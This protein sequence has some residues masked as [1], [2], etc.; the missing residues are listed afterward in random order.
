MQEGFVSEIYFATVQ[1]FARFGGECIWM[2]NFGT[3]G[4]GGATLRLQVPKTIRIRHCE[5]D[6]Q[7]IS[8]EVN[9]KLDVR[10]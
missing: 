7:A 6:R 3:K 1:S 8:M 9:V 4:L 10:I 2:R 5:E